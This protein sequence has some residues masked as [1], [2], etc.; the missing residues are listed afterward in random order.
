MGVCVLVV[1]VGGWECD[2]ITILHTTHTH[3]QALST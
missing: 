3:T 2:S 1:V